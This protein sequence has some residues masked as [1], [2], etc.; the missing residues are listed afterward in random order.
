MFLDAVHAAE[1]VLVET[2][3]FLDKLIPNG[4]IFI[5]DTC[6]WRGIMRENLIQKAKKWTHTKQD[7]N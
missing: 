1:T 6:R 3:F 5:H 7:E 2:K 4:V